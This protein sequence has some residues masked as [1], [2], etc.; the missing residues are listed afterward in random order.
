MFGQVSISRIAGKLLVACAAAAASLTGA[1][2]QSTYPTKPISL[3]V[4]FPAG[5]GGDGAARVYAKHLSDEL[6]QPVNVINRPGGNTIPAVLSVMKAP[7]DG[8]TLLFDGVATNSL[9]MDIKDLPYK[10]LD[11]VYGPRHN[12]GH[13]YFA[14]PK[15]S[16]HKTLDD[17]VKTIKAKPTEFKIAWLGGTS[18]TDTVLTSFLNVIGLKPSDVKRVP[19]TGSGPSATALAGGHID[20]ATGAVPAIISLHA[21]GSVR[22]VALAGDQ[23]LPLLPDVPSSKEAGYHVPLVGWN[24]I[25]GPPGLPH[26]IMNKIE[27]T[28]KRI[29]EKPAFAEDLAKFAYSPI[30][31]SG[32]ESRAEAI[33]E[34][35]LL[36]KLREAAGLK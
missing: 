9:Q 1:A 27:A 32:A 16:P 20:L 29:T 12:V 8:Y 28:V 31:M 6:K 2:A 34:G 23:R 30:Y 25:A 7:A 11:R 17:V 26:E 4:G 36:A 15:D 18:L 13:Y 22:V 33:K 3:V 21:A 24:G 14:V 10:V 19:F 35:E 5:G